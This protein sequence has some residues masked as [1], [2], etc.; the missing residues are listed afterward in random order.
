MNGRLGV[1]LAIAGGIFACSHSATGPKKTS[2]PDPYEV[3]YVV[4]DFVPPIDTLH[5]T[6]HLTDSSQAVFDFQQAE[7]LDTI[8]GHQVTCFSLGDTLGQRLVSLDAGTDTGVV[9]HY[10]I[11][12]FDP[13]AGVD[14]TGGAGLTP[15]HPWVWRW[16]VGDSTVSGFPRPATWGSLCT[17]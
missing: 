5:I 3:I 17:F 2:A 16:R 9:L 14:T 6:F 4:D 7:T 13:A 12:A 11:P 10:Q 8:P 15:E 1:L